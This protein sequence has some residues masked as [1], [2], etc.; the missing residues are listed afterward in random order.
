ME[1]GYNSH[2]VVTT[3]EGIPA[4]DPDSR[5]PVFDELVIPQEYV[6]HSLVESHNRRSQITP[7]LVIKVDTRNFASLQK[8]WERQVLTSEGRVE[9]GARKFSHLDSPLISLLSSEG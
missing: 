8:I 7:F 9:V 1:S 4:A 3:K 5:V 6:V 2:F